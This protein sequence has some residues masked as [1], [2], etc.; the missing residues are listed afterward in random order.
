MRQW[1]KEKEPTSLLETET[2]MCQYQF[3]WEGGW[4]VTV[5]GKSTATFRRKPNSPRKDRH[6][7]KSGD[8][9]QSQEEKQ[10]SG[11]KKEF[12][13]NT[14]F[15]CGK[16]G[17]FVRVPWRQPARSRVAGTVWCADAEYQCCSTINEQ[18]ATWLQLDTGSR[19]TVVNFIPDERRD[20][21]NHVQC[22]GDARNEWGTSEA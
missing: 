8:S 18:K 11:G 1:L 4:A 5:S 17:H 10:C 14:C 9:G 20:Y 3:S 2:L 19:R 6:E 7:G 22:H 12:R 13:S 15:C 16:K 21:S